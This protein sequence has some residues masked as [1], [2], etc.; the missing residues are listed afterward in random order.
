[1]LLRHPHFRG[2]MLKEMRPLDCE[3]HLHCGIQ[4][5]R[6]ELV[7]REGSWLFNIRG[8]CETSTLQNNII[9]WLLS[10]WGFPILFLC[11]ETFVLKGREFIEYIY[12]NQASSRVMCNISFQQNVWKW[13]TRPN[14][15][16]QWTFCAVCS[17]WSAPL[18]M[19]KL[20]ALAHGTQP[21]H[22]SMTDRWKRGR[23]RE[24]K[25]SGGVR[26]TVSYRE[27]SSLSCQQPSH[28]L[29]LPSATL[30]KRTDGSSCLYVKQPSAHCLK[31]LK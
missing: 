7:S 8:T 24:E 5:G 21:R 18:S 28:F 13:P 1:M 6:V 3:G 14:N 17:V 26:Q 29:P 19:Q 20:P 10:L 27:M 31:L 4:G 2:H 23:H 11:R 22:Q 9:C 25:R 30:L 16:L 15:L 12:F